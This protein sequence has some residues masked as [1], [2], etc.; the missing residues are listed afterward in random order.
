MDVEELV[1]QLEQIDN[2][3]QA[4]FLSIPAMAKAAFPG[5]ASDAG[6]LLEKITALRMQVGGYCEHKK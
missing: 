4:L 1:K 3:A 2:D 6:E 5:L